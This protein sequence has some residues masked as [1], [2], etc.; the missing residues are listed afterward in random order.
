MDFLQYWVRRGGRN[1][2]LSLRITRLPSPV[3]SNRHILSRG[4][5]VAGTL[6]NL[7]EQ[8]PS[9]KKLPGPLDLPQFKCNQ[10]FCSHVL[11]FIEPWILRVER[12]LRGHHPMPVWGAALQKPRWDLKQCWRELFLL[13]KVLLPHG[14]HLDQVPPYPH[15][16]WCSPQASFRCLILRGGGWFLAHV[17]LPTAQTQNSKTVIPASF[18]R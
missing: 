2:I 18:W 5:G 4:C 9:C 7:Q 3:F 13:E 10:D 1:D 17:R 12:K 16:E 14:T 6:Q 15:P 11:P 8:R